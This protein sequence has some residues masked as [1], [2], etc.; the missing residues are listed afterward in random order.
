MKK[1][2]LSLTLFALAAISNELQAQDFVYQPKNS[3]FG[4]N[5]LNHSWMLNSANAQNTYEDP[6]K[7]NGFKR[8]PLEEFQQNLNRQ[9]LNQLSRRIIESQFG[10]E[11]LK[12]GQYTMGSYQIDIGSDG[13]GVNI[14]IYDSST[15]NSTEVIIPYF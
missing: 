6:S 7:L 3:A 10:E 15:G 9:I 1:L 4:G 2:F 11:G 12:D 14:S 5:Y 13:G 8:D